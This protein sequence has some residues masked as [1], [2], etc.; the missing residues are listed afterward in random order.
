[1]RGRAK[2][3]RRSSCQS[4]LKQIALGWVQYTQ[5]YD[6]RAVPTRVGG[7]TTPHYAWPT[8]LQP[9][10]KS[11]QIMVCPSDSGIGGTPVLSY[12]YS[13]NL[14]ING[15]VSLAALEN[16]TQTVMYAD[17]LG[18]ASGAANPNPRGLYFFMNA[19]DMGGR[20][21][22][23]GASAT[24]DYSGLIKADR[25]L[26]GANYAFVDGHVKWGKSTGTIPTNAAAPYNVVPAPPKAGYDYNADSVAG[27]TSTGDYS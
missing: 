21:A 24:S 18:F 10:L 11:T 26:E 16:P 27:P 9:Y 20:Y 14:G 22:E 7:S 1:M 3:A 12:T 5:D 8:I 4:N 2:N 15:G 17:A 19:A 25:H 13:N 6:E 23:A